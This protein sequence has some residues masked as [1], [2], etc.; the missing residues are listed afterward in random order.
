MADCTLKNSDFST[1]SSL[2]ADL[3]SLSPQRWDTFVRV[4]SPLLAFWIRVERLPRIAHDEV[5]Q[6]SLR[7]IYSGIGG[8]KRS[9][10]NGSFRGWLRTIIRR[11]VSDYHRQQAKSVPLQGFV[12]SELCDPEEPQEGEALANDVVK[13]VVARACEIVRQSVQPQT[14]KMFELTVLESRPASEVAKALNVPA[15]NVRMAKARVIKQLREILV[16]LG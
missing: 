11:R 5:L 10:S 15:P 12:L 14:W 2:V 7:A 8:F 16:D 9:E 3:Q 6:E 1:T 13:D 4:Y